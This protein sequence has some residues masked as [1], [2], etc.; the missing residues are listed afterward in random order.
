MRMYVGLRKPERIT[1][2]GQELAGEIE[3]IGKDVKR[4]KTGDQVFGPP[5]WVLER[6]PST[7]VSPKNPQWECWQR[8]Q[9]I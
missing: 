1:I 6:M 5:V 2:L 4:F 3:T 9:P 8:N 7:F